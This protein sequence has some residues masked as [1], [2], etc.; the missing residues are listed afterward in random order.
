MI[1]AHHHYW[2]VARGDYGW[3]EDND[4]VTPIRRDFLPPALDETFARCGVTQSVV[5][6]AAPTIAET[7]FL[8]QLA[9]DTPHI[10]KVVGWIDFEQRSSE[11]ELDRL[12]ANPAFAGVRPMIQDIAD[13]EWMH[14]PQVQWAYAALAERDLVFDALGKSAHLDA[15]D[16]LFQRYP[17]LRVVIDHG[18]KPAIVDRTFDT[19]AE[20][21]ARIA[22]T[23]NVCCKISGLLTEAAPD[24][25]IEELR[26]Y[27]DHLR[28]IFGADR[29]MWG[30]D[31]PVLNLAS[32][33]E[34]WHS[35]SKDLIPDSEHDA[36]FTN[37]AAR[38]YR[39]NT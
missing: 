34:E 25:G 18:M 14:L 16:R 36:I 13:P 9:A 17:D 32:T 10:A 19:W 22:E 27:V 30:S 3:M 24:D 11:A 33:Y 12:A 28:Q 29:L 5:V 21:M 37:T 38:F 1:D 4:A 7:D 26:P 23:S 20:R 39:I 8:L 31:W 35:M 2:R 6:Q 15:F